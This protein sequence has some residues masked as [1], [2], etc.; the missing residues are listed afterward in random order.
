MG[1]CAFSSAYHS[2]FASPLFFCSV[3]LDNREDK[4]L[5]VPLV[6]VLWESLRSSTVQVRCT[7]ASLLEL[8]VK[9]VDETLVA[10]RFVPA[11]VTLASDD[12]M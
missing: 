4:S 12:D 1:R 9:D 10:S 3:L 2:T 5:H 11:L 6:D 7:T 8:L